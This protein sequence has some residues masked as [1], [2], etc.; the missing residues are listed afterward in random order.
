MVFKG[1][2]ALT[3]LDWIDMKLAWINLDSMGLIGSD[4]ASLDCL[5]FDY[6]GLD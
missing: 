3:E 2:L 1:Y 5:L 6:T 4:V